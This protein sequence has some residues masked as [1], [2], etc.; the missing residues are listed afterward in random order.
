M[1]R[2]FN[3]TIL[4]VSILLNSSSMLDG[5]VECVPILLAWVGNSALPTVIAIPN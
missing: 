2:E 1:S 4:N 3:L 5:A